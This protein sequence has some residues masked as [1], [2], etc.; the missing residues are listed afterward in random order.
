M[1]SNRS[2]PT[3]SNSLP[4]SARTRTPLRRALIRAVSAARREMST[5]VTGAAPA[6]AA[7]IPMTPLP[8]QRSQTDRPSG[9][10]SAIAAASIHESL[11]GA[12]TPGRVTI[13]IPRNFPPCG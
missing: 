5:A 6:R 4:R 8:Q 9:A 12:N 13:L 3:A 7:A 1:K 2:E 11:R 10:S